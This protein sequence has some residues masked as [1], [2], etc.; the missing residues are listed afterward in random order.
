MH[1]HNELSGR[2]PTV[3]IVGEEPRKVVII[4]RSLHRHGVRVIVAV[5]GGHDLRVRSRA[6]AG[7]VHLG[8]SVDD[9]AQLLLMLARTEHAAW[10]VPTSDSSLCIACAVYDDLSKFCAVG[11]PPPNIVQRVLDKPET[12]AVAAA[13]GVPVPMSTAIASAS[14]LETVLP[15]L[16]FPIIAKP[17]DKS[18]ATVHNFKTRTF[19]DSAEL[20]AAFADQP[21]FGEGLLFQSYHGGQG[22][23]IE[24]LVADGEVVAAFQHRRLSENPPSGGVAVVAEA[25]IVDPLLLDHSVRLLKAL[26]WDGVA[27]VEYRHDRATGETALMEVNGRFWGSLPLAVAAGM[28]FP[29]YA[30]QLSQ[31]ITPTV[32]SSYRYGLRVRW[33]AGSLKRF[34]HA[35]AD[36]GER[37]P[38]LSAT[39]QLVT[40]F[41]FGTR[42]AMWA[43]DDPAPAIQESIHVIAGW[44]KETAK[45]IIRAIVPVQALSIAKSARTLP[46]DRRALYVRRRLA[47]LAGME[48]DVALPAVVRSIMFVCHGNIMRSASAAQF[49]RDDLAAA[50]ISDIHVTSAG[51]HARNGKAADPRVRLAARELGVN[52]DEHRATLLT[53]EL[54]AAN[55]VIFAMDEFNFANILTT[56]P[57]SRSKLMLF[58]G[59]KA[60]GVYRPHE[61]ADPY[62]VGQDGVSA[63]IGV[64]R[65]Y[66]AELARA[67][68]ERSG[69]TPGAS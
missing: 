40:D 57:E 12:L 30:W 38:L 17:G 50:G 26:G 51:T 11:C 13:C 31:G 54:I 2:A 4:A 20:R 49:L 62:T 18:Q 56:F 61:I 8:S 25:E 5:Q 41:R 27:M 39:R 19:T 34:A 15:Q 42:S 47:R 7:V 48:R 59:M 37:I 3:I 66:V 46:S 68:S 32:P 9:S 10:I 44:S 67:L 45:T 33:T 55:D 58:G 36:D 23:G 65:R 52:L 14:E 63:T 21:R 24:L 28:D 53:A 6:I 35:F 64:V 60:S 1:P 16:H 69:D 29:L 22:V 43:S